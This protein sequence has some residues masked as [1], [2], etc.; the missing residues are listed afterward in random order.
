MLVMTWSIES[1]V[2]RYVGETGA[3]ISPR[4]SHSC[5]ILTL[6]SASYLVIFGGANPEEGPLND[7]YY[8][9]LPEIINGKKSFTK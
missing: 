4:T 1:L 6:R 8:A 5:A 9:L 3:E 7:S 2:W